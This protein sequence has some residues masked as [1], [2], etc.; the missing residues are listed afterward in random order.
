V[1]DLKDKAINTSKNNLEPTFKFEKY[2]SISEIP[3]TLWNSMLGENCS[4]D[5][6][7]LLTLEQVFAKTKKAH[8]RWKF[9]YY[10]VKDEKDNPCLATYFTLC[11]T[12]DDALAPH[13]VSR[14]IE[15]ER[16]KNPAYLCS[17]AMVMGSPISV[18]KHLYI[19]KKILN[20]KDGLM[21]F[22]E[23]L[24]KEF[25]LLDA[26]TLNIRDLPANDSELKDFFIDQGFISVDML[27]DY[28]ITGMAPFSE[29]NFY[30]DQLKSRQKYFVRKRALANSHLFKSEILKGKI[31]PSLLNHLYELYA[32][33]NEKNYELNMFK[34]P[35]EL[36]RQ[37]LVQDNWEVM[38]LSLKKK[39][40]QETSLPVAVAISI[41]T[42]NRYNFL[43]AGLDYEYI[44]SHDIYSQLLWQLVLRA[45]SLNYESIGL[46]ITTGQ[47]KRKFGAI[48]SELKAYV[49]IKDNF[50]ASV[51]AS[52][53]NQEFIRIKRP[54][55]LKS[56]RKT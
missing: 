52:M 25:E 1:I 2:S 44:S 42:L 9:Y 36:F 53:T 31:S 20:W 47:N 12:K 13:S 49:Q 50:N 56:T 14:E 43:I 4:F 32:N 5:W 22:T 37:A 27:D 18:G 6:K 7:G 54:K 48:G 46:G 30:L 51:I 55:N 35:K 21:F 29:P 16:R 28:N 10:L 33:V 41:K 39:D 15:L 11:L 45:N 38:S 23:N 19:D 26:N 34:Y 8:E 3:E 24:W 17:K 40:E